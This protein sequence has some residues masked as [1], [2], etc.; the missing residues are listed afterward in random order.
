MSYD[1]DVPDALLRGAGGRRLEPELRAAAAG[2]RAR[3]MDLVNQ[4]GPPLDT[5]R[6]DRATI[7]LGVLVALAQ[8]LMLAGR[9]RPG[10]L[11]CCGSRRCCGSPA[12]GRRG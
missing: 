10:A 2:L 9:D 12:D 8:A 11:S 3:Q 4:T 5:I 1:P 7:R 6:D